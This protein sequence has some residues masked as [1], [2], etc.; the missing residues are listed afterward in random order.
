MGEIKLGTDFILNTFSFVLHRCQ[1]MIPANLEEGILYMLK[2][3]LFLILDF[4]IIWRDP[5]PPACLV[6]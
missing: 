4:Q 3:P 2:V 6:S 5:A 1:V